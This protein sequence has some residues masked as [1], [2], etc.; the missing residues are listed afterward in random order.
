MDLR[1]AFDGLDFSDSAHDYLLEK[2]ERHEPLFETATSIE[3]TF[4]EQKTARGVKNDYTVTIMAH[5]SKKTIRVE[6]KSADLYTA[7]DQASD[8][9]LRRVRKFREKRR[10]WLRFPFWKRES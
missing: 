1:V 3:A 6:K 7:I 10:F 9:F 2:L 5:F 8:V 4:K